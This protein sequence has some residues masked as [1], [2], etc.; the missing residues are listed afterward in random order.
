MMILDRQVQRASLEY[1]LQGRTYALGPAVDVVSFHSYEDLDSVPT[2]S[3]YAE[4]KAWWDLYA[5]QA[6][7]AYERNTP[8]WMTEGGRFTLDEDTAP[9]WFPQHLARG[10]AAGIDR[11]PLQDLSSGRLTRTRKSAATFIRLFPAPTGL[12]RLSAP[13]DPAQV[14]RDGTATWTYVAWATKGTTVASIPVRTAMALVVDI[15]GQ[16]RKVA[17]KNGAVEVRL[18]RAD[19]YNEPVYV[20][21]Q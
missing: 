13:T 2:E 5:T 3:T 15:H 4:Y 20:V 17:A 6:G 1:V 18:R 12:T 14:Y 8:F 7:F 10:F 9:R 11:M 21:E 16:E 19:T